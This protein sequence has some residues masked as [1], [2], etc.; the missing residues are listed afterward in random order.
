M[1]L[2]LSIAEH[3]LAHE[4][5][6][7]P[8][9]LDRRGRA[10]AVPVL[11][12]PQI[13][14]LGRAL[15]RFA[16]GKPLGER[17]AYWLAVQL[18]NLYGREVAKGSYAERRRWVDLHRDEIVDSATKSLEG[19]RFWTKGEKP[20][21]FL[22]AAKEWAG[23]LV[24]GPGFPSFQP[25]V[26]DGTCNVLQ[27]LSALGRDREGGF[28]TNLVPGPKPQDLYQQVADRLVVR[29]EKDIVRGVRLAALWKPLIDRKLVKQ[30]TMTTPYGVKPKSIWDQLLEVISDRERQFPSDHAAVMYIA[31]HLLAAIDEVMVKGAEIAM[32][33]RPIAR[34]FA[35][36]GQCV[37]WT[38]PMG[39][40]VLNDYR[41]RRKHRVQTIRRTLVIYERPNEAKH[42]TTKEI[43]AVVA[44]L[45]H[46]LDAA[47]MMLTVAALKAAGLSDFAMVHDSYAV[48]AC[49]VDL[50]HKILREQ[51]IR[52]HEQFTLGGFVEALRRAA[53]P[54]VVVPDPPPL[55][56]LNLADV[57]ASEY[58]F[59]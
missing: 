33:L 47:H 1:G 39:F 17:G 16:R 29:I 57:M 54:G 44:N 30:A 34:E 22:A 45:I 40:P 56:S 46:S 2:Q 55:G 19:A 51:F 36:K 42:D 26:M 53:P 3:F 6:W 11:V 38:T 48:H 50:M 10:Y 14:D 4:T 35:R 20:L 27:H 23:Y 5:F 21:R 15:I 9:Q 13:D 52:V 49:D 37:S 18:A 7:F 31:P 41:R 58:F 8:W 12:N 28:W 43:D 24:H 59:S 25:I 32:W